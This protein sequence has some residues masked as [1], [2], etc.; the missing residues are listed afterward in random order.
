MERMRY[1][2]HVVMEEYSGSTAVLVQAHGAL[3]AHR[4]P[5][6][7][8]SAD[9]PVPGWVNQAL[10]RVPS[11]SRWHKVTIPRWAAGIRADRRGRRWTSDWLVDLWLA[12]VLADAKSPAAD[13]TS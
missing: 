10:T 2:R 9:G 6:G 1:G 7:R 11:D 4:V 5:G 12:E 13:L 8:V 3:P